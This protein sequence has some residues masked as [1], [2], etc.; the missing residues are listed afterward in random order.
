MTLLN[1]LSDNKTLALPYPASTVVSRY[2]LVYWDA[3]TRRVKPLTSKSTQASE[4]LDQ[5]DAAGRFLGWSFDQ[6]LLTETDDGALRLVGIEGVCDIDCPSQTFALHD[7]VGPTWA[8]GTALVNQQVTRVANL[9]SAIAIVLND[10]PTPVTRVRVR[11]ISRFCYDLVSSRLGI[12]GPSVP[13]GK[14]LPDAAYT[15]LLSDP[16]QLSMA[17]SGARNVTLPPEAL[18]QGNRYYFTNN[19]PAANSVTFLGSAGG[20]VK[21]NGVV[22]QNKTAVVWC[23]GTSWNGLVSA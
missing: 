11:L 14:V 4:A 17:P 10:Y 1:T 16:Q 2:D 6:R 3:T 22:P 20:A 21:G 8:G 19:A 18:S 23:D 13:P 15:V 5:V 7:L 12:S 9:I